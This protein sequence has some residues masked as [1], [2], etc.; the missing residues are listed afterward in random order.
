MDTS[1]QERNREVGGGVGAMPLLI[2]AFDRI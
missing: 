2:Y 1:A